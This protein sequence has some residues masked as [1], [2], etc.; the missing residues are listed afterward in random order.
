MLL[1]NQLPPILYPFFFVLHAG[2]HVWYQLKFI[3]LI[4]GQP[5]K[6]VNFL[7]FWCPGW[8]TLLSLCLQAVPFAGCNISKSVMEEIAVLITMGINYLC[9][10]IYWWCS[11][12][13]YRR[14][15]SQNVQQLHR[16]PNLG[17]WRY[18][19]DVHGPKWMLAAFP[20]ERHT[21]GLTSMLITHKRS[22][23][24]KF[25][26]EFRTCSGFISGLMNKSGIYSISSLE[27]RT[28]LD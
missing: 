24:Y 15:L 28:H 7:N 22:S 3:S 1:P 21:G 12:T 6:P 25:N 27:L 13:C 16:N 19:G 26:S 11:G 8:R 10:W 17:N 20:Y 18:L 23:Q 9:E 2:I 4:M 5:L 14:L